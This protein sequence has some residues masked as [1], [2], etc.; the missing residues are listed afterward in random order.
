MEIVVHRAKNGEKACTGTL[1][2]N[3]EFECY[4]LE[5]PIRELGPNGE[6]KIFGQTGIPAGRY[7][8]TITYSPHFGRPLPL[9]NDVPF[10]SGIRIH[11]ANFSS[12]VTGCLAIGTQHLG[13]D[14]IA[15]GLIE[16]PRLEEKL[17]DAL[18]NG[19]EVWI[20]YRNEFPE[21]LL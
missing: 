16:A 10:F 21:P 2:I 4:T 12:Q 20:D 13:D 6:G 11:S 17:Y 3:G 9:V 7:R 14:Y 18:G 15:G 5:D 8:V 1:D 19:E